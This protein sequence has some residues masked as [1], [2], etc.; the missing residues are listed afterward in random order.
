M[1]KNPLENAEP[2]RNSP[3]HRGERK[4]QDMLGVRDKMESVG[5][6][7][8]RPF[9]LDQH[10]EF[11]HDLPMVW[12]ASLDEEGHPWGSLRW[13]EPGF[14]SAP[15]ARQLAVGGSGPPGDPLAGHIQ[16]DA[17]VGLLGLMLENRR[18]NRLNGRVI[19]VSEDG[20]FILAVGQSFGNC[21]KYIQQRQWQWRQEWKTPSE[22]SV[23]SHSKLSAGLIRFL[24]AADTF[25]I[26]TSSTRLD[27][28]PD[29][30]A[31]AA[32]IGAD[33]SHRG[34]KPGFVRV[35]DERTIEFPD[36]S[37]NFM[38][39]TLGN[40]LIDPRAALVFPNFADGDLVQCRGEAEILWE[41]THR[42]RFEGAQRVV[43]FHLTDVR[44]TRNALPF[45]WS[46]PQ[47]SPFNP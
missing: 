40:L 21:P 44:H 9:L 6:R 33:M 45:R 26:A 1:R 42:V 13:G 31:Q 41:E 47:P 4:I 34:G 14:L 18:R 12:I 25:F 23:S 30:T 27:A 7:V 28:K 22:A 10:R 5:G 24:G 37:G 19:Q 29:S 32:A 2:A 20:G 43:R 16:T 15:D 3:F 11:F 36:Y 17:R 39:N 38:F 8:L 46:A 35:I